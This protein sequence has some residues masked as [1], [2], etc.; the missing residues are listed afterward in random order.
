MTVGE[1]GSLDLVVQRSKFGYLLIF[2][3]GH[4]ASSQLKWS[5][6]SLWDASLRTRTERPPVAATE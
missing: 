1:F 4:A 5:G 2:K 6:Q 3:G